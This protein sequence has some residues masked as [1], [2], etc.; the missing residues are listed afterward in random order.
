MMTV[1]PVKVLTDLLTVEGERY[2]AL[3]PLTLTI[4][5]GMLTLGSYNGPDLWRAKLSD[6]MG[7]EN[8]TN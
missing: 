8:D 3:L 1:I 4:E 5:D 6:L 2:D 7:K